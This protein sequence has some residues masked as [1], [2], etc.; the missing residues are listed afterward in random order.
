M[1]LACHQSFGQK[2]G[3]VEK[4]VLSGP[5]TLVLD[6]NS[7][8]PLSLE[9]FDE[10][11]I[12]L[13]TSHFGWNPWT[14]QV[15]FYGPFAEEEMKLIVRYQTLAANL[16]Q[17]YHHKSRDLILPPQPIDSRP[18]YQVSREIDAYEP[19][20][21]LNKSG[22]ITRGITVGNN[23][24]LVLNSDLNL[25]LS[26]EI[27]PNTFLRA[28]ISDN[29]LPIQTGGYTQRLGEFDRAYI[30]IEQTE[31]GRLRA[32][33]YLTGS[34]MFYF[35]PYQRKISGAGIETQL[36]E[37][38]IG[39]TFV[40]VDAALSRGKF[41]RNVFM[42]EEGN[43]GPYKLTGAENEQFIIILS[44]TERV[45]L[46]GVLQTR[47]EENDYVID[48]NAAEI[49]FTPNQPMTS[50][51]RII[52]EFQYNDQSYARYVAR[53]DVEHKVDGWSF[54]AGYFNESDARNQPLQQGLS[55]EEQRYLS[56]IGNDLSQAYVPSWDSTGYISNQANYALIDSL[57]FD[58]VFVFSTDPEEAIYQVYFS[59]VG[60]GNGNYVLEQA[61][62]NG[63]IFKWVAPNGSN[64]QG[65]Y[66]PIRILITPKNHEVFQFGLGYEKQEGSGFQM[67]GGWSDYD[68]NSYSEL[69]DDQ[70]RGGAYMAEAYHKI[71]GPKADL[72]GKLNYEWI[73]GRFKTVERFRS[74]EF[75]RDWNISDTLLSEDQQRWSAQ[76]GSKFGT[77]SHLNYVFENLGLGDYQANRH[78]IL[79]R[80]LEGKSFLNVRASALSAQQ[81]EWGSRFLREITRFE[82]EWG[83]LRLGLRSEGELNKKE[84]DDQ[85]RSDSYVF[86]QIELFVGSKDTLRNYW[87][88]RIFD[89][90][91]RRSEDG[92]FADS[93]KARSYSLKGGWMN[94]GGARISGSVNYR[95]FQ[96]RKD[97]AGIPDNTLTSRI[98]YDDNYI[99]GLIRFNSF[100]EAG[101]GNEAQREF[102]YVEVPAGQGV[103]AW[104][105]Y[106]ENGIQE[107]NEFE[108]AQFPDEAR[109]LRAYTQ[110]NTYIR[111][112][113]NQFSAYILI[114]PGAIL[115]DPKVFLAKWSIQ[116][117]YQSDRR[118]D[119][120]DL[121]D[122][123]NPFGGVSLDSNILGVN[124]NLRSSLFFNRSVGSLGGEY[125][126]ARIRSRNLVSY[127][128]ENRSTYNHLLAWRWEMFSAWLW[129]SRW[130]WRE[131][132]NLVEGLSNRDFDLSNW[133]TE[134]RITY[135]L[136]RNQR[137]SIIGVVE[138][139]VNDG[140][141]AEELDSWSL[142][143]EGWWGSPELGQLSLRGDWIRNTFIGDPNSPVGYEMLSG[144]QDGEN[145][146]WMIT[147]QRN[148]ARFLQLSL[149]YSG[150]SSEE[151]PTIHT[152]SVQLKAFF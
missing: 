130:E 23:Q 86:H 15:W 144:L 41:A 106:N 120:S 101:S 109:F 51:R 31:L 105:D 126:I 38:E 42:G 4:E 37:S 83:K 123:I 149:Q 74:V 124:Q 118:T 151:A 1:F 57:G 32:G 143:L 145:I 121:V 50:A 114:Q 8:A 71:V 63:R 150:R 119:R 28:S 87:Q 56:T 110:T 80:Y 129:N 133:S 24:D 75:I 92:S 47:G 137:L 30:E 20:Q 46:D 11:G 113:Y 111:N 100:Y 3:Y 146:T 132:Q 52:V 36:L 22:S 9:L 78:H 34:K 76:L 97:S 68:P 48:Y 135:Q 10:M 64:S 5:D 99:G 65:S 79:G 141:G 58:T 66:A 2:V 25:Q 115:S 35:N 147:A 77:A 91:D 59:F 127:G 139:K 98:R 33:D 84:R 44:G 27:A 12:S 93:A 116:G 104:N 43:Q 81:A 108:L 72:H 89:R 73:D 94:A 90:F 85:L 40:S 138:Q 112:Y 53:A 14:A 18:N 39:E 122:G 103:Y 21:G 55:E 136:G 67:E 62:V 152:G 16:S 107:L 140:E 17:R 117:S 54:K 128:F 26:G 19:F 6:T 148:L 102:T 29:N 88:A 95:D 125:T 70:N 96:L 69:D 60:A 82:Q 7:L 45:Y 134:Q 61:D 13:D 49:I 131:D 142:G